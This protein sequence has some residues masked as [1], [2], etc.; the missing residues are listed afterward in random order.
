[1]KSQLAEVV[2]AELKLF[3]QRHGES[4]VGLIERAEAGGKIGWKVDLV[5]EVDSEDSRRGRV[6]WFEA[7]ATN[8]RRWKIKLRASFSKNANTTEIDELLTH[9]DWTDREYGPQRQ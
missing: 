1:M 5:S 4:N 3:R 7:D 8:D 9:F 2:A 6:Y